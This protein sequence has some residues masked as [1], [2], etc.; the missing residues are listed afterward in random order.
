MHLKQNVI[1]LSLCCIADATADQQIIFPRVNQVALHKELKSCL[2]T[3][4][5]RPVVARDQAATLLVQLPDRQLLPI[6]YV[7][8]DGFSVV[9][10]ASLTGMSVSAIKVGVH[11]GLKALAE[12]LLVAAQDCWQAR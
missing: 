1:F 7:K 2:F 12:T 11:R 6:Q 8:L 3:K 4:C 5:R 9:E 10:A